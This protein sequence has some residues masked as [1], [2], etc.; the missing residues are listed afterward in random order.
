MKIVAVQMPIVQDA[1]KNVSTIVKTIRDNAG[2]DWI[3]FPECAITNW[4]G[5]PNIHD[6]NS[7]DAIELIGYV[8]RIES[9]ARESKTGIVLGT[10]W[11]HNGRVLNT[12]RLTPREGVTATYAKRLVCGGEPYETGTDSIVVEGLAPFL[13]NDFWATP[14]VSKNNPYYQHEAI[15]KGATLF[16]VSANANS[17]VFDDTVYQYHK[18]TLEMWSKRMNIPIIVSNSSTN[19]RGGRARCQAPTGILQNGLWLDVCDVDDEY[20]VISKTI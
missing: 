18:V 8:R 14:D 19:W 2:A 15:A 11:V 13:C 17:G 20:R 12:A 16:S 10:S 4:G 7:L 5:A 6:R 9:F 1:R 3:V